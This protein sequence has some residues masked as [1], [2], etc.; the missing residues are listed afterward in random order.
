MLL[1]EKVDEPAS[2]IDDVDLMS[3]ISLNNFYEPPKSTQEIKFGIQSSDTSN[4]K[5]KYQKFLMTEE[6]A[7][8]EESIQ[9]SESTSQRTICCHSNSALK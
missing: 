5:F 1:N 3:K 7:K 8:E 6:E 4:K 2:N 9:R